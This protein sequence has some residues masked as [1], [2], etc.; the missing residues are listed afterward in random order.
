MKS[1]PPRAIQIIVGSFIILGIL[2]LALAGILRPVLG[3]IMDP[4]VAI[5]HWSSDRVMAIV[6]FFTLPR[7][8]TDLLKKNV[9]L[10]DEVSRLTSQAIQ[11]AGQLS[12]AQV[13]YSLLDFARARPQFQYV[14][15]AVIGRDPSPFLRYIIIDHGSDDGIRHGMPVV[16]QQ[17]LVGRIDAVIANASRVQLINDAGSTIDVR[18][19]TLKQEAQLIGSVTGDLTLQMI[20]QDL[21]LNSGEILLTSGLGGNYPSD[22]LVGQVASVNKSENELF[23]TAS[24]QPVVDFSTLQAVLVITNFKSIDISPLIPTQSP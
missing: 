20:P 17:G 14:A 3:V 5:Q 21:E 6:D 13:L 19:Q 8:V 12:E 7:E 4:F 22:L 23:Q 10:E 16:T 1:L 2:L 11:Q 9:D 18:M 24:V 15:S